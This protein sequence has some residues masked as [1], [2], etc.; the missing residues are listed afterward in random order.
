M[1]DISFTLGVNIVLEA[2]ISFLLFSGSTY[3]SWGVEIADN[4]PYFIN[5]WWGVTFPAVVIT[6][7][8]LA[9]NLLGDA[10]SDAFDPRLR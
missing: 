10:I 7:A 1:V 4:L 3:T 9:F 2:A 5:E 8:V 6:I